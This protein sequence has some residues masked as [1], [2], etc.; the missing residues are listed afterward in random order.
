MGFFQLEEEPCLFYNKKRI[1]YLVVYVNDFLLIYPKSHKQTATKIVKGIKKKYNLT[2]EDN[3]NTF[4]SI[5]V[6]KDRESKKL[7]LIYN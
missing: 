7:W 6:I 4:L 1:V 2:G 3:V 5:C